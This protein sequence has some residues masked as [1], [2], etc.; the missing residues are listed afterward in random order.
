MKLKFLSVALVLFFC[1][2]NMGGGKSILADRGYKTLNYDEMKAMWI[3][4]YDLSSVYTEGGM[5]RE[6]SEFEILIEK[7]MDN[8]VSV[9]INTVIVQVRPFADSMYP[10]ELYPISYFVTGD[11]GRKADYDPFEIILE[12]AHDRDNNLN[13]YYEMYKAILQD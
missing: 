6:R 3:S 5:Q 4:Q 11:Y 2:C 10:S 12:K 9:G 8:V 1:S 13:S 7:M